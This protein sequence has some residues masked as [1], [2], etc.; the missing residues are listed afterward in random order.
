MV[1]RFSVDSPVI[2]CEA[3]VKKEP[4]EPGGA[5]LFLASLQK[6]ERYAR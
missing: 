4:G 6:E 5:S 2:G 1:L 3:A